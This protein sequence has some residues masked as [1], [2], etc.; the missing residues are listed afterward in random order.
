[1]LEQA[2]IIGFMVFGIYYTMLEGEIFAAWSNAL[3]NILPGK[4]HPAIFECPICMVPWYGTVIYWLVWH[5]NIND[6]IVSIIT[7]MGI[8]FILNTIR[9]HD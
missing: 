9:R 2:F 5:H 6:W 3:Y 1:M 8:N 4:I 7:A